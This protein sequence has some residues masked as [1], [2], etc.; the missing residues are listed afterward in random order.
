MKVHVSQIPPEGLHVAGREGAKILDL[1]DPL[2]QPAGDIHYALDVGLSDG[3]L[4]A[5]GRLSIDLDLQCVACLET[6]RF[7]LEVPD[8]AC[9]V[10]LTGAEAVDLTDPVREDILLALPPHPHC[11]WNGKRACQGAPVPASTGAAA[12]LALESEAE[13]SKVVWG[14]LDQLKLK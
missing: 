14:A 11:D 10:E 3:G 2:A 12:T 9:Q 1:R 4:F 5:T 7:P 13:R 8:F 6:F